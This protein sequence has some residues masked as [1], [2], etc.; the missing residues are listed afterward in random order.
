MVLILGECPDCQRIDGSR[1]GTQ[2]KGEQ[3]YRCHNIECP[4]TMKHGVDWW[5]E[6]QGM[7]DM[8]R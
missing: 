1:Y 2:P 8:E 3:R 4:R 5:S 7:T 6:K